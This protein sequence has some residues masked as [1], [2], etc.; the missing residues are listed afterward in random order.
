MLAILLSHHLLRYISQIAKYIIILYMFIVIICMACMIYGTVLV[1]YNCSLKV[2]NIM[3]HNCIVLL[4]YYSIYYA[5]NNYIN[6][7]NKYPG[8]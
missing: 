3:I 4:S 6:S 8:L 5:N 2:I 1:G 7:H